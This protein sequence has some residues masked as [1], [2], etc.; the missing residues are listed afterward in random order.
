[1]GKWFLPLPT[2]TEPP[3]TEAH[4]TARTATA[5]SSGRATT[6]RCGIQSDVVEYVAQKAR[7]L[8]WAIGERNKGDGDGTRAV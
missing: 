4:V 7:S 3:R 1:M 6:Q 2:T 8:E 5:V